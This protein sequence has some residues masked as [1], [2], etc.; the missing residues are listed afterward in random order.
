LLGSGRFQEIP[1]LVAALKRLAWPRRSSP[2]CSA[3]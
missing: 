2:R 1:E 3:S